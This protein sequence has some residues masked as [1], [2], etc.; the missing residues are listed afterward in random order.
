M[1]ENL[2]MRVGRPRL[3]VFDDR[4]KVCIISFGKSCRVDTFLYG[5]EVPVLASDDISYAHV[6]LVV[7]FQFFVDALV[8]IGFVAVNHTADV[9]IKRSVVL[10]DIAYHQILACAVS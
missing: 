6:S 8:G 5:N 10:I 2:Q 1:Q 3:A 4:S 7:C 9:S